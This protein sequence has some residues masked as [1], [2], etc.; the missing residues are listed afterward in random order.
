MDWPREKATSHVLVSDFDGTMTRYDFYR[1]AI[2]SLLPPDVADHWVDY[3]AGRITHFQA[4]RRYF[5]AIRA[6]EAEVVAVVD[7]M[8]LE[9]DLRQA[10]DEL[11]QA[12]W[13]V[14]VAS[15]GCAWYIQRLLAVAEVE[16]EVHA[17]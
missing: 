3:R 14:I 12:G 4:L 17:N 15:A 10:I 8:E 7:R 13:Q 9:P 2:E 6:S 1:L 16:V 5:A 11:R